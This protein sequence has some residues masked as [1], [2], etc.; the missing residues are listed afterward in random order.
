MRRRGL[1]RWLGVAAVLL[2][3]LYFVFDVVSLQY[4]QSRAQAQIAAA[5]SAS[6]AKVKL[7]SIPFLPGYFD[8]KLVNVEFNVSGATAQGGFGVS[9]IDVQASEL[10]FGPGKMFALARSLFATRTKVTLVKPISIVQISETDLSEYIK[11]NVSTVGDVAVK[12]TGIEI[13]FKIKPA[14]HY[15]GYYYS[16]TPSP[17]PTPSGQPELTKPARY[18]PFVENHRLVLSLTTIFGVPYEFQ[19]DAERIQNLI[20]LPPIPG[21]LNSDVHLG[22]GVIVVESQGPSVTLNVGEG[23]S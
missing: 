11:R 23:D 12:A 22:K 9:S 17:T 10:R 16:A 20:R 4:M 5:M 7:G 15:Y 13:R 2:V 3:G 21:E 1:Y 14:Q 19:D 8:G 6:G 18:L